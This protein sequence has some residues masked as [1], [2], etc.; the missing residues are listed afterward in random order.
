MMDTMKQA[1]I[2]VVLVLF[3]SRVSHA[4]ESGLQPEQGYQ[5]FRAAYSADIASEVADSLPLSLA[6]R[7]Q[8]HR[9]EPYSGEFDPGDGVSDESLSHSASVAAPDS[10]PP[11]P[12]SRLLPKNISFMEKGLWGE[13]GVLRTTGLFP[14][15]TPDEREKEISLRRT[16]LSLHQIGGFATL[17]LMMATAY[18]GQRSID[19]S[20]SRSLRNDHQ[21]F[22][23]ATI[24]SYSATGLLAILSPPPLI[25]RDEVSTITVHKTLAWVHAAGMIITP[26]LGSMI[27][28]HR[29]SQRAHIHQISGYITTATLAAAMISV[30]F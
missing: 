23:A 15:L 12:A 1:A 3:C 16:M 6:V 14:S 17:G 24:V 18:F 8:L 20:R 11:V 2:A 19:D 29:D 30:T 21:M 7:S 27:G 25:R 26:I 5:M 22:V 13:N 4:Q 9:D 28:R 10:F